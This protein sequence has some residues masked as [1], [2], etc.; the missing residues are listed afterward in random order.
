MS[1]ARS[2][3]GATGGRLLPSAV[4]LSTVQQV[5]E[6]AGSVAQHHPAHGPCSLTWVEEELV[7][8]AEAVGSKEQR[9]QELQAE[10]QGAEQGRSP[11]ER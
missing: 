10:I 3:R 8:A 4:Q 6:S 7:A 11:G 5:Q 2:G 9:V 1:G